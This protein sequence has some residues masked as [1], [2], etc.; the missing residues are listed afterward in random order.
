MTKRKKRIKKERK[1]KEKNKERK[2][3]KLNVGG[4]EDVEI[5]ELILSAQRGFQNLTVKGNQIN[6]V[7]VSCYRDHR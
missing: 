4:V 3:L 2:K 6:S 7:S 5:Q 1:K